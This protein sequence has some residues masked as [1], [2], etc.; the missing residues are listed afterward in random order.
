LNPF[1]EEAVASSSAFELQEITN[2]N[3]RWV[4]TYGNN[5][6]NLK[7]NYTDILAVNYISDGKNLNVTMWLASGFENNSASPPE[8]NQPFRK[9]SYGMLIDADS[10]TKT[11]YNGADY[12]FYLEVAEGK[13]SGYLYQLSTT[14]GYRLVGSKINLQYSFHPPG[15]EMTTLPSNIAIRQGQEMLVPARI[16]S[17]TG[18]SNDVINITLTGNNN[19]NY[20][21]APGFN[22]D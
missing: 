1:Y 8:Y 17:T 21:I 20:N 14:G 18:Y 2:E 9:I 7:S 11:G 19:N 5:D 12:D 3:R 15:L 13:L 16:K 6:E 22:S 10:N 4:Q